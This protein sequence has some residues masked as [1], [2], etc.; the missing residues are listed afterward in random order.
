[1]ADRY[2]QADSGPMPLEGQRK[3]VRFDP[4][5]NAGTVAQILVLIV[6]GALAFG[7]VKTELATQK[8]EIEANKIAAFRDNAN[9]S[10]ALKELKTDVKELQKGMNDVKE[11][12]AILRG[13][14]ATNDAGTRK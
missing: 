4:T 13:R 9:T 14:A 3:Y 11:S 12:L 6:G 7:A 2:L 1:M 8:V 5:F 10:E